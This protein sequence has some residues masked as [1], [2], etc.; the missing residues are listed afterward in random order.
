MLGLASR[1]LLG[2]GLLHRSACMPDDWVSGRDG[3]CR[4][5]VSS[6]NGNGGMFGSGYQQCVQAEGSRADRSFCTEEPTPVG[7]GLSWRIPVSPD[8]GWFV[9]A[10][11][12]TFRG[13]GVPISGCPEFRSHMALAGSK[14]PTA[15][16]LRGAGHL[17]SSREEDVI[18]TAP[19]PGTYRVEAAFA[20]A[21]GTIFYYGHDLTVP[22][23]GNNLSH[24]LAP[25]A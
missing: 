6:R 23:R 20:Q 2:L 4:I 10:E 5:L 22:E 8:L 21:M 17:P 25:P 1:T 24:T 14:K 7:D 19:G 15:T 12:G 13:G 18:W 9:T 3:G 11:V 16:T